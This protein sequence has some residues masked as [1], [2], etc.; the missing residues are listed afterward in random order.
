MSSSSLQILT[1]AIDRL[2]LVHTVGAN[3]H[4]R[5][6]ARRQKQNTQDAPGVR[7]DILLP[8]LTKDGDAGL[9]PAGQLNN[10][11]RGA[12]VQTQ[13]VADHD[14]TFGHMYKLFKRRAHRPGALPNGTESRVFPLLPELS[15]AHT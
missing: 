6:V 2:L 15:H 5:A 8:V 13:T 12:R 11:R 14:L 3:G 10:L 9:I 4:G 7:F 1:D